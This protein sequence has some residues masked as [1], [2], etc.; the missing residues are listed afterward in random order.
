M[1]FKT[2]VKHADTRFW[3][4]GTCIDSQIWDGVVNKRGAQS[5]HHQVQTNQSMLPTNQLQTWNGM[6]STGSQCPT[7]A[8]RP[9]LAGA[10][11]R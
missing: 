11:E 7:P 9:A 8:D 2:S 5:Y 4:L 10:L 1:R 6:T 3:L